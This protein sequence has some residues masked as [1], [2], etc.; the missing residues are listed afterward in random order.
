M[1]SHSH[2]VGVVPWRGKAK[3]ASRMRCVCQGRLGPS[4][5]SMPLSLLPGDCCFNLN[6]HRVQTSDGSSF[7]GRPLIVTPC[8]TT[9]SSSNDSHGLD[10][11]NY[12]D[13][14]WK[15]K[16][17][18]SNIGV[19]LNT[20]WSTRICAVSRLLCASVSPAGSHAKR[21]QELRFATCKCGTRF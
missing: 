18:K 20:Q 11:Q 10:A 8:Q 21:V 5:P 14:N 13:S 2:S 9:L 15:L 1:Q 19:L 16:S 17:I 12:A 7:L 6:T 4:S 3:M